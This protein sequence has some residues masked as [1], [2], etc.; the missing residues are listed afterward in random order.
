MSEGGFRGVLGPKESTVWGKVMHTRA[1]LPAL[2]GIFPL[3]DFRQGFQPSWAK[4][5]LCKVEI[6][7]MTTS[8]G[9]CEDSRS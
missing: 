8:G 2:T 6:I 1:T 3:Y 4:F 5:P 9:P 7:T